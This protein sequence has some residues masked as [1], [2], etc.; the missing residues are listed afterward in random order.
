MKF[1]IDYL[2]NK[3][4]LITFWINA[5]LL[6]L[7]FLFFKIYFFDILFFLL[8]FALIGIY[9]AKIIKNI[10]K[11][12]SA[13]SLVFSY[14]SLLY[15]LSFIVAIF[16]DF[17][18]INDLL[19]LLSLLIP[20]L[21]IFGI[22][23]Q[24]RYKQEKLNFNWQSNNK[25]SDSISINKYL[26]II[27]P[28]LF[29]LGAFFLFIARTGEYILTPWASISKL[30]VYV[31][32]LITFIV[33]LFVFSRARVKIIL[34]FIILHSFL[35]HAYLPVVYETGF[36]GDKWRHLA[37]EKYLQQEKVYSPSLFGEPLRTVEI[38]PLQ[39]PE[40]LIA[41]NKTS[42]GNQWGI[43]I[44]L[45]RFLH[46]DIFW[47]DYLFLFVLWSLI[48]PLLLF[49]FGKLIYNNIHFRL[50]LAFLPSIFYTFQVFGSITIPVAIGSLFFFWALYLWLLYLRDDNKQVR[51]IAIIFSI[52]MYLGYV[53]H[54]IVIFEIGLLILVIK[55]LKRPVWRKTVVFGLIILFILFI[56]FL[57][58]FMGYGSFKTGVFS[59]NGALSGLANAFGAL[60][61]IIAFIPR[62]THIDQGNWLFNQTR[63]TQTEASLFTLRQLPFF[64]TS[65]IW[66]LVVFG[67]YKIRKMKFDKVAK[68]ICGGLIV[69]ICN[70]I[71]SWYFMD[72]NHIL[73]RRLDLLIVFLM[74][75]MVAL[76]IYFFIENIFNHLTKK[77]KIYLVAMAI[78]I[79][80]TATY[81]SGP[82][83]EV[84]TKDEVRAAEYIWQ[85]ID[86]TDEKYCVVANTW[87]LLGLEAAS[88]REIIAGGFP[89]YLEYAQPE[90]VKI[91]EGM[92]KKPNKKD[93]FK[94]AFRVT[95]A[96][97]CWYMLEK[98]WVSDKIFEQILQKIGSPGMEIGNVMI[99]KFDKK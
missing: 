30:Y 6:I 37:S 38:G 93:W 54:F 47:I 50:L 32:L 44:L 10:L 85:E 72:G 7:N 70:Y 18:K 65:F 49:K 11:W 21:I 28:A 73:A 91:F 79:T 5:F 92:L 29:A 58:I 35:L 63:L 71:I 59:F 98:R 67:F 86:K 90:R 4:L 3:T 80:A 78:A 8:F 64:I 77:Q 43:T 89:V 40:V 20:G 12:S 41:G 26:I 25:N 60:T 17:Y 75:V 56:P 88:S 81:T 57:E 53:L 36:G 33:A 9:L 39:V 69:L 15:L 95:H 31:F 46:I 66:L 27:L 82:F 74:M 68:F 24:K 19:L 87:P 42:Y 99:W 34:L 55:L 76:G 1:I 22:A 97:E 2:N 62:P 94:D 16:I 52:L 96:N 45:A 14:F 13:W 48:L 51:N 83:L 61:G 84:V 23:N